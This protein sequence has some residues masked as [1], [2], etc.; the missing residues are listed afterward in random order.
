MYY[1]VAFPLNVT[2][3]SVKEKENDIIINNTHTSRV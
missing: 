1:E 2:T 3:K